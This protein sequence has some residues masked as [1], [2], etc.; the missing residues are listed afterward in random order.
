MLI[1]ARCSPG[2]AAGGLHPSQRTLWNAVRRRDKQSRRSHRSALEWLRGRIY[3]A[4]RC[5]HARVLR[6]PRGH[7]RGDSKGEKTQEV[8]PR[9][10]D[11]AHRGDESRVERSVRSGFLIFSLLNG[12]PAFAGTTARNGVPAFAGTTA[13]FLVV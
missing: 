7:V 2:E 13:H 8:E 4:A 11:Q 9:M 5:P 12:V 10:E 1:Q 3:Q 6:S